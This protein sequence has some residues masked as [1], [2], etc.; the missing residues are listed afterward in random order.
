M[1]HRILLGV[2]Q[3]N[4]TISTVPLIAYQ[5]NP[6]TEL[7]RNEKKSSGLTKISMNRN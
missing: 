6:N 3:H 7:K 2:L 5:I 4:H 1:L